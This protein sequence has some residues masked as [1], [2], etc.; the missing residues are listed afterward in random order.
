MILIWDEAKGFGWVED[1]EDRLFFHSREFPGRSLGVGEELRYWVGTDIRGRP[2]ARSAEV[3]AIGKVSAGAWTLL[4]ALLILPVMGLARAPVPW[5]WPLVQ[6]FAL[7]AATY[8]LYAYDKRQAVRGGWRVPETSL[9]LA[10]LAGGWPGAFLAQRRLRHKC[11]KGAYLAIFW[12]IIGLHQ[13]VGLDFL[14]NHHLSRE[15]WQ[16]MGEGSV[17]GG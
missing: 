1:G 13:V 6:A 7:S 10:E 12:C 9:Q 5:W 17:F 2:C 16:M 3:V 15:L 8:R 11:S 14:L 4:A